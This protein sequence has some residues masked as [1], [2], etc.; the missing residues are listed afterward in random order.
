[1]ERIEKL[2]E[3]YLE[4][5]EPVGNFMIN[6]KT[7]KNCLI[8]VLDSIGI[9]SRSTSSSGIV[10]TSSKS[11]KTNNGSIQGESF[12]KLVSIQNAENAISGMQIKSS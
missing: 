8:D 12:S 3:I 1:M 2:T 7:L 6:K 5:M 4:N 9:G 10:C 11:A